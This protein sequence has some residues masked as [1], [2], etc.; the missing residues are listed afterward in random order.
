M[1]DVIATIEDRPVKLALADPP[2]WSHHPNPSAYSVWW[3]TTE[4]R[5]LGN[6]Y[7]TRHTYRTTYTGERY[8]YDREH[9]CWQVDAAGP[10]S[11]LGCWP[12]RQQA[13][14]SLVAWF[15][16]KQE[17]SGSAAAGRSLG[18]STATG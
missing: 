16:R 10:E 8:G 5:L 6:V 12:N 1:T 15:T 7:K 9:T 14:R 2:Q 11:V 17:V 4:D 18:R 13:V 3:P